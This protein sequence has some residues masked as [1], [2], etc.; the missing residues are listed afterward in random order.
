[1]IRIAKKIARKHLLGNF[2]YY[3]LP[4][5]LTCLFSA[6]GY[7]IQNWVLNEKFSHFYNNFIVI[8]AAILL[9]ALELLIYP[10]CDSLVYKIAYSLEMCPKNDLF[11]EIKQ[12]LKFPNAIKI[13]TITFIPIFIEIIVEICKLKFSYLN[14]DIAA[15]LLVLI[16]QGLVV[17]SFT[18]AKYYLIF[19]NLSPKDSIISS[20]KLLLSRKIFKFIGFSISFFGWVLLLGAIYWAFGRLFYGPSFSADTFVPL[21]AIIFRITGYGG[22]GFYLFPYMTLSE[23]HFIKELSAK[24]DNPSRK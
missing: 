9:L 7:I 12:F 3:L 16:T 6:V 1:M 15:M 5:L 2:K 4:T 10:L 18:A 8:M 22:I 21:F 23:I 19:E 11:K 14:N 20:F 17:Y 24:N 13:F